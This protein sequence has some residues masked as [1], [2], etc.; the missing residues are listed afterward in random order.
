M[1]RLDITAA[2]ER[3]NIEASIHFARYAIAKNLVKGKK[4]LD[5]ACGEGYGSFLLKQAGADHVV[6]VDVCLETV[7]RAQKAFGGVGLEFI[8]ADASS[9]KEIFPSGGFDVVVSIE[10]VEHLAVPESF[11]KALACVAGSDAVII[12][13]CPNDY[14]YFPDESLRNPH[15][16]RKFRFEEFQ[17]IT[18][19]ALGNNV[20]W[21]LG[22]GVFGFGSTPLSVPGEFCRVPDSW[23]SYVDAGGGYLVSGESSLGLSPSNCSYFV[24][25]W[26]APTVSS[27]LAVFPVSMDDYVSMVEA[28]EGGLRAARADSAE[29]RLG[30]DARTKDVETLRSAL[31]AT[32]GER[33]SLLAAVDSIRADHAAL[34]DAL[35]AS[36]SERQSIEQSLQSFWMERGA[37]QEALDK[38]LVD[39]A[40]VK[41]ALNATSASLDILNEKLVLAQRE[42]RQLGLRLQAALVENETIR[43]ALFAVKAGAQAERNEREKAQAV[44][45]VKLNSI[46]QNHRTLGL[47]FHAVQ[48]ENEILRQGLQSFKAES[49]LLR[50]GLQSLQVESDILRIGN[51]RYVRL[52]SVIPEFVRSFVARAIRSVRHRKVG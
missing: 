42:K 47:R 16:L 38:S 32:Q 39:N 36:R 34:Q 4:V 49:D 11:L 43:D 28:Q 23:M 29:L 37:V 50:Q 8:A 15:H 40:L 13:S 3:P 52:R 48:S 14:W 24:G 19:A 31:S 26:N 45:D 17:R 22:T 7:Q 5:L 2:P 12:V 18:T 27:G 44:F 1:E 30:L 10:T 25:V 51:S 46:H 9:I 35:S 41:S 33:N 6:G 21:S 20:R